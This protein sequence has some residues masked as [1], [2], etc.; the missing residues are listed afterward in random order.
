MEAAERSFIRGVGF[1]ILSG[2]VGA[3]DS[4]RMRGGSGGCGEPKGAMGPE[5][6]EV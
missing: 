2:R 5:E 6:V 1:R 4:G 3:G